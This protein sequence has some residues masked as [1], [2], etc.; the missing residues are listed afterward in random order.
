MKELGVGDLLSLPKNQ[1]ETSTECKTED[2][3]LRLSKIEGQIRGISK[4]VEKKVYCDDILI[5]V[6]AV[7]SALYGVS[8]LI[9]ENQLRNKLSLKPEGL[10]DQSILDLMKSIHRLRQI[11][12]K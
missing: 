10:D 4:M 2:L 1:P 12:S 6:I 9:L 3:V 7:Q 11:G 8:K 5:Q